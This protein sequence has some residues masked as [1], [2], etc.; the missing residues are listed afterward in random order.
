[1][2]DSWFGSGLLFSE[3]RLKFDFVRDLRFGFSGRRFRVSAYPIVNFF[4]KDCMFTEVYLTCTFVF[5][6]PF[7]F[8]VICCSLFFP[9]VNDIFIF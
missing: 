1:M 8:L 9:I 7:D 3:W 4:R 6:K 5:F 2:S